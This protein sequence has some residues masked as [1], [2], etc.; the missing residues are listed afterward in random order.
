MGINVL[1]LHSFWCSVTD[2]HRMS[3]KP[4]NAGGRILAPRLRH[5]DLHS[6][7]A[8]RRT[9]SSRRGRWLWTSAPPCPDSTSSPRPGKRLDLDTGLASPG[10]SVRPH[11]GQG[12]ALRKSRHN[13][14]SITSV[15]LSAYEPK[16][17]QARGRLVKPVSPGADFG[18]DPLERVLLGRRLQPELTSSAS[19]PLC[20]KYLSQTRSRWGRKWCT[21]G[22]SVTGGPGLRLLCS[23]G[24]MTEE[25]C[26]PTFSSWAD[27]ESLK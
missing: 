1:S 22:S 27:R 6:V 7:N 20:H 5:W 15:P 9:R 24:S 3:T 12:P 10:V 18:A 17:S 25:G 13:S 8:C 26:R 4:T 2:L 11:A 21:A 16:P 14:T 19:G 23:L